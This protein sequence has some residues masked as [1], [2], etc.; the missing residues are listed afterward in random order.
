MSFNQSIIQLKFKFFNKG[1]L[2]LL[3]DGE[4]CEPD[5]DVYTH[6]ERVEFPTQLRFELRGKD[7]DGADCVVDREGNIVW[8]RHLKLIG[9]SI[10]GVVPNRYFLQRWPRL[11]VGSNTQEFRPSNQIVYANYF[12]FN[13]VIELDFDGDD[14]V[15]WLMRTHRYKD[16]NWQKNYD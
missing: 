14:V 8:D 6:I 16:D 10:D 3:Y 2:E 12:G 9:A 13:G 7:E 4:V 11:F 5:G 15:Q 1:P